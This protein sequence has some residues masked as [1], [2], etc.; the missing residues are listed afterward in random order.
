MLYG[1]AEKTDLILTTNSITET[2][3]LLVTN[4]NKVLRMCS[5][6]NQV[7]VGKILLAGEALTKRT[8]NPNKEKRL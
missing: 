4:H 8:F 5:L 7:C 6:C 3:E 1:N 2:G